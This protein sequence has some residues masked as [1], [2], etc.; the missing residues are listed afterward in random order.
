MQPNGDGIPFGCK[1]AIILE[2]VT[3]SGCNRG[4]QEPHAL[5]AIMAD[6]ECR[7]HIT[8]FFKVLDQA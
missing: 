3:A 8:Q 2:V 7:L 6:V 5:T 4:M 1:S